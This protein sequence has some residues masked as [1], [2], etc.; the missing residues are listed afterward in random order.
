MALW[1]I[2]NSSRNGIFFLFFFCVCSYD[3][4]K[5]YIRW[6]LILKDWNHG[7][8]AGPQLYTTWWCFSWKQRKNLKFYVGDINYYFFLVLSTNHNISAN[9]KTEED[10]NNINRGNTISTLQITY[11][12]TLKKKEKHIYM[13]VKKISLYKYSVNS[14]SNVVAL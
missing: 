7:R 2:L 10:C 12:Y 1:S 6:D 5:Y 4:R 8:F 3:I 13:F 11:L 14:K 9:H